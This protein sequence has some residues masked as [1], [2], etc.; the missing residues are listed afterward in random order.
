MS[1]HVLGYATRAGRNVVRELTARR[2]A[3]RGYRFGLGSC[4]QKCCGVGVAVAAM[5]Y[6]LADPWL[7]GVGR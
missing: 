3:G 6:H 2:A 1:L 5:T 4:S 7:H